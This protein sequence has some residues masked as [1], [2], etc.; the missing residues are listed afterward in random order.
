[1]LKKLYLEKW[2]PDYKAD[3]LLEIDW[4]KF[5]SEGI[6]FVFLDIDNTLAEHGSR[7][8]DQ[9]AHQVVNLI[10][11]HDL[12]LCILSNALNNRIEEYAKSLNV[13]FMGQANKPS[14]KQITAKLKELKVEPEKTLLI[15]DQLFTDIWAG[16]KA[17]CITIL[18]K[19]R[20][21]KEAFQVRIKRGLE[22]FLLRRY[23]NSTEI[24]KNSDPN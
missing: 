10:K 11:E 7:Q 15:G 5:K 13:D 17:G 21:L 16:N 6:E 1:M 8:A 2:K 22:R 4:A 12:P 19:Q 14:T 24:T 23:D 20:F 9:Y 18:V 3:N